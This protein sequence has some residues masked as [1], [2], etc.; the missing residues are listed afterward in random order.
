MSPSP[1]SGPFATDRLNASKFLQAEQRRSGA[2][3]I[4]CAAHE[5]AQGDEF[6]SFLAIA[7]LLFNGGEDFFDLSR[8][9]QS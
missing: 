3:I 5:A 4:Y 6:D 9:L 8:V 7:D 1:L 2:R